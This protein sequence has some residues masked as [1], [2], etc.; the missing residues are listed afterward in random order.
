MPWHI[1]TS[2]S[3]SPLCNTDKVGYA[4]RMAQGYLRSVG[5]GEFTPKTGSNRRHTE[6]EAA[7]GRGKDNR[8]GIAFNGQ[9]SDVTSDEFEFDV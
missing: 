5:M 4:K 1:L 9:R 3:L 2:L 6:E 7:S 8:G